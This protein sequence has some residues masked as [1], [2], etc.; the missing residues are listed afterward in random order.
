[1]EL[2]KKFQW[3]MAVWEKSMASLTFNPRDNEIV[4][5]TPGTIAV[6]GCNTC[7]MGI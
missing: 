1:M 5:D 2:G 6:D 4:W 3:R 7:K